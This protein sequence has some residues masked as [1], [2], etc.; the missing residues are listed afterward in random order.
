MS[1]PGDDFFATVSGVLTPVGGVYVSDLVATNFDPVALVGW[2]QL[3]V[4]P[5][6]VEQS[7]SSLI[8][9]DPLGAV[10]WQTNVQLFRPGSSY[11][12]GWE[13]AA[14]VRTP[15]GIIVA[16]TTPS[17]PDSWV[18][19]V[20]ARFTDDGKVIWVKHY[21]GITSEGEGDGQLRGI[22]RLEGSGE[23]YLVAG[24]G[25]FGGTWFFEIDG[26]GNVVPDSPYLIENL[27][28][29]RLRTT[30]TQG[31]FAVGARYETPFDSQ[32]WL[33]DI[34]PV[35]G[36]PRWERLYSTP[37]PE[38]PPEQTGPVWFDIAEGADCLMVVGNSVERRNPV[39]GFI[40]CLE[41]DTPEPGKAG[42]VRWARVG[43]EYEKNA[44]FYGIA[45]F[46]Y[47]PIP[48]QPGD[49]EAATSSSFAIC[50]D[51]PS[52]AGAWLL[53]MRDDGSISWQK[54]YPPTAY[55]VPII[56][57]SFS[58]IVTS[59]RV[60]VTDP[61]R[62]QIVSSR[63]DPG[64]GPLHCGEESNVKLSDVEI[65]S[66]WKQSGRIPIRIITIPWGHQVVDPLHIEFGCPGSNG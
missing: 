42:A 9:F 65:A 16:G 59:G 57:P 34:D 58:Q 1:I 4:P 26:V 12:W 63:P 25:W 38:P 23:R 17:L 48:L 62:V 20:I 2:S 31:V 46:Q 61:N 5:G 8:R 47:E 29:M 52:S 22:V 21:R 30:P 33:I 39:I 45:S 55:L 35:S 54:G 49:D 66:E 6:H 64:V 18:G 24:P 11:K 41:K 7:G 40:A 14:M 44:H 51:R 19:I 32:P 27:V 36:L 60:Y 10:R 3:S 43:T 28:L 37:L 13:D 53:R 56:W 15:D 50:G